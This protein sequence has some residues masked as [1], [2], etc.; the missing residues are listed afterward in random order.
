MFERIGGSGA[1]YSAE[2]DRLQERLSRMASAHGSYTAGRIGREFLRKYRR[3]LDQDQDK[4]KSSWE[5]E[6]KA[7]T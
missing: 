3:L 4:E 7:S 1:K 6:I 2:D 5:S